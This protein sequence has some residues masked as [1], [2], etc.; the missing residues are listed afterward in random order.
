MPSCTLFVESRQ[1]KTP[2]EIFVS[3]NHTRA[4]QQQAPGIIIAHPY[5]PLGMVFRHVSS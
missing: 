2:L 3:S 5:G 4:E 1:D